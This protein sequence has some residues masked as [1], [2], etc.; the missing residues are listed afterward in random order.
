MNGLDLWGFNMLEKGDMLE[1]REYRV[2]EMFCDM[3]EGGRFKN[4][5]FSVEDLNCE[6]REEK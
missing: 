5:Y 2:R 3:S 6:E 4:I 1:K